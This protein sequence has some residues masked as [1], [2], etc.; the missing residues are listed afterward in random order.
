MTQYFAES[1]VRPA[2]IQ[3][4]QEAPTDELAKHREQ[5]QMLPRVS[6]M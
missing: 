1:E 2:P 4:E 5:L 6:H 3:E